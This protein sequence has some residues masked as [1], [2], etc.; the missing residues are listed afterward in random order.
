MTLVVS[1][2]KEFFL[3]IP[4]HYA[5]ILVR[6]EVDPEP[7]SG[8]TVLEIGKSHVVTCCLKKKKYEKIVVNRNAL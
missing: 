5:L 4:F 8:N 7:F 2:F 3:Y 1:F 6:V